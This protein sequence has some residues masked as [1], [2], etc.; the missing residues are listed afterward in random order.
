[1]TMRLLVI[2]VLALGGAV[3]GCGSGAGPAMPPFSAFGVE[4]SGSSP[5]PA[6]G[7]NE[8]PSSGSQQSIGQLCA[9]DCA[10]VAAVCQSTAS[11]TCLSSCE[12]DSSEYPACRAQEQAFLTCYATATLTC[13][14]DGTV[15]AT[16]CAAAQQALLG[17][18][19]P[20]S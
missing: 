6:G 14:G 12:A 2:A 5:E 1:M 18:L 4:P 19:S 9:V 11:T 8:T 15:Q 16:A 17:C 10:R 3:I 7:A 13:N 20:G